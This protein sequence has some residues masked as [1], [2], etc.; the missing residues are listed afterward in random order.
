MRTAVAIGVTLSLVAIATM[1]AG[2]L[3][4]MALLPSP[5]DEW[6]PM[7]LRLAV[8]ASYVVAFLACFLGGF[9]FLKR[10]F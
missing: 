4:D 10:L 5:G 3:T 7:L 8:W 6:W 2:A 1:A 9:L